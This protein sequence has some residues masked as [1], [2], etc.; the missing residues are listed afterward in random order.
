MK[1]VVV[2]LLA[3]MIHSTE[4]ML[5]KAI[6]PSLKRVRD[7]QNMQLCLN[8]RDSFGKTHFIKDYE[9]K[10][11]AQ[12]IVT[13]LPLISEESFVSD[14]QKKDITKH[15][16]HKQNNAPEIDETCFAQ[17][18]FTTKHDIRLIFSTLLDQVKKTIC[19]AAFTITDPGI[20]EQ[21]KNA[22]K[23][24]I[25]VEIITDFSNINERNSQIKDLATAGIPICYYSPQLSENPQQKGSRRAYMH[26]KFMLL[27]DIAVTGSANF[28]KSGQ[29][30]N[31]ENIVVIRVKETV[32]QFVDE[33]KRL[34][35]FCTSFV[36]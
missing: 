2:A 9:E 35:A 33:F 12:P 27:D 28:T 29:K 26:H 3:L 25:V 31:I 4:C 21:L 11:S 1:R 18:F 17:A 19:I 24:G 23:A 15:K 6:V 36:V 13:L 14:A 22:H 32:E 20:A 16:K 7:P 8:T 34:K 30:D 10:N 5:A